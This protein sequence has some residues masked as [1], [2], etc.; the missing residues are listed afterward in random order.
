ME[1]LTCEEC[2]TAVVDN[3]ADLITPSTWDNLIGD[4]DEGTA[5]IDAKSRILLGLSSLIF[6]KNDRTYPD[7]YL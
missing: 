2:R 6:A 4:K 1:T 5:L 3:H 7:V